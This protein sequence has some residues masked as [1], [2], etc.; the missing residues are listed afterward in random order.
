MPKDKDILDVDVWTD[1]VSES[2]KKRRRFKKKYMALIL[3]ALLIFWNVSKQNSVNAEHANMEFSF[4]PNDIPTKEALKYLVI[5]PEYSSKIKKLLSRHWFNIDWNTDSYSIFVNLK[6]HESIWDKKSAINAL[7]ESS[8][9]PILISSDFEGWYIHAIDKLTPEEIEKYEVPKELIDLR[10]DEDWGKGKVSFFPSAEY[11]GKKYENIVFDWT[12]QERY[13]FLVMMQKYWECISRIMEDIWVDIVFWPC[14]DI[15]PDFD[16]EKYPIAKHDRSFWDNFI[17]WQD[18]I[19]AFVNWFQSLDSNVLLVPKH[20]VWLWESTTDPHLESSSANIDRDSWAESIFRNLINWENP[21]LDWAK[22]ETFISCSKNKKVDKNSKYFEILQKNKWFIEFLEKHWNSLS[23]WERIQ[24]LMTTHSKWL[25]G[26]DDETITYSKK[27]IDKLKYNV[28][29][30]SETSNNMLFSDDL[31]MKWAEDWLPEWFEDTEVNKILLALSSWH[32]VIMDLWS[33]CNWWEILEEV[34][35]IIDTQWVDIDND[36]VLDLD[37]NIILQKLEKCLNL[38]I[39]KWDLLKTD[40]WSYRLSDATYFDPSVW[41]VI[42]DAI[43]SNQWLVSWSWYEDYKNEWN[44][45]SDMI[46][47]KIKSLYEFF[48]HNWPN[49]IWKSRNQIFDAIMWNDDYKEAL[50]DQKKLVIVDKSG[51]KMFIYTL[52]GKDLLETHDVWVW[53]W[54]DKLDYKH[55]RRI[56]WDDKTPVWYYMIVDR[57]MW[58]DELRENVKNIDRYWWENGWMLPMVWPWTPYVAIHGT[59]WNIWPSSNACVRVLDES[60][61][62]DADKSAQKAINH[63][64]EILPDWTFVIITN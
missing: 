6:D 34:A 44:W 5:T 24:A 2:P 27:I 1:V 4:D 33:D 8:S 30:A 58:W 14:V 21:Q 18:L 12:Y 11:L 3:S 62:G 57:V 31:S 56:L 39:K 63:L 15:V 22:N 35:R 17:L 28:W 55:D 61:R 10:N 38:L 20:Y 36:G 23:W 16:D 51:C 59:N 29:K 40:E 41:K 37:R 25:W 45:F 47:K 54:S 32:D 26:M 48:V 9:R 60:E 64:S 46:S 13:D 7:R 52:D 42:R 53:K 49:A 43:Y 19:S 50:E